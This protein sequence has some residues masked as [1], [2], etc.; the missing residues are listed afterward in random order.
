MSG[1]KKGIRLIGILLVSILLVWLLV[2]TL[3]A[4][5]QPVEA[6][7]K[8]LERGESKPAFRHTVE[9]EHPPLSN[10]AIPDND[11]PPP[12]GEPCGDGEQLPYWAI[13]LHGIVYELNGDGQRIPLDG[14]VISVTLRGRVVTG[15]TFVHPG[16]RTPTYGI[17]ISNLEP[18]FMQPVTLTA[19]FSG[20]VVTYKVPVFPDLRDRNQRFDIPLRQQVTGARRPLA[21][22]TAITPPGRIWG[23]V[24]DFAAGGTIT[25]AVIV[26][27]HDGITEV[28]TIAN[29]AYPW[30]FF[31][32]T[33]DNLTAIGAEDIGDPVTLTTWFN[34]DKQQKVVQ[35]KAEPTQ[36]DLITGWYCD[37]AS[38]L[39]RPGSDDGLPD[40]AGADGLPDTAGADGLPDVGCFWGYI[41]GDEEDLTGVQVQLEIDNALHLDETQLYEGESRPRYGIA[42]RGVEEISGQP[43]TVTTIYTG[44]TVS[45][46]ATINLGSNHNQQIDLL[47]DVVREEAHFQA[48]QAINSLDEYEGIIWAGSKNGLARLDPAT[49]K[50]VTI[51][52]AEGPGNN[53]VEDVTVDGEGKIW[54]IYEGRVFRYDPSTIVWNEFNPEQ[55]GEMVTTITIGRD[56]AIYFGTAS[57]SI[58]SYRSGQ[59]IKWGPPLIDTGLDYIHDLDVD[60]SGN[61]WAAGGS[62][63]IGHY[64]PVIQS[65]RVYSSGNTTN[66]IPRSASIETIVIGNVGDIWAG[67][68]GYG[69]VHYDVNGTWQNFTRTEGGLVSNYIQALGVDDN[70]ALWFGTANGISKY[71]P[72]NEWERQL[73]DSLDGL[74][75]RAIN[76]D[77]ARG[78]IR[79]GTAHDIK[80]HALITGT[81]KAVFSQSTLGSNDIS[82]VIFDSRQTLWIGHPWWVEGVTHYTPTTQSWEVIHGGNITNGA[83]VQAIT[84]D[85]SDKSIWFGT[86]EKGVSHYISPD[87][88][89]VFT[90]TGIPTTGLMSNWIED[91]LI[92]DSNSIWFATS[93]GVSHY[94]P[95]MTPAWETF[96]ITHGLASN[97]INDLDIYNGEIWAATDAGLSL[98]SKQNRDWQTLTETYNLPADSIVSIGID[99][100]RETIW[101]VAPGSWRVGDVVYTPLD[102]NDWTGSWQAI[103]TPDY[104]YQLGNIAIDMNGD[105]WFGSPID[106]DSNIFIY[107]TSQKDWS[108]RKIGSRFDCY[109]SYHIFVAITEERAWLGTECEGM[110]AL[111]IPIK[112]TDLLLRL[113]NPETTLS[114]NTITYTLALTNQGKLATISPTLT[115]A[116]PEETSFVDATLIPDSYAPLTWNLDDLPITGSLELLV[117]ATVQAPPGTELVVSAQATTS[118]RETYKTNNTAIARTSVLDNRPD[119]RVNVIAP[120][121]LEAGQIATFTVQ[122]DNAGGS[123][124]TNT[125]VTVDLDP[126]LTA[127][128]PLP[129]GIGDLPPGSPETFFFPVRV[130]DAASDNTYLSIQTNASTDSEESDLSNNQARA[131]TPTSLEEV[132][133]LFLVADDRM[134]E[135][136]GAAPYL[137]GVYALAEHPAVRGIVVDVF[138]DPDVAAAYATWQQNGYPGNEAANDVATAL[139]QLIN[140]LRLQH[141]ELKYLVIVGGDDVIPFYRVPDRSGTRWRESAY[142]ETAVPRSTVYDALRDDLLLTDDYYTDWQPTAIQSRYW[143]NDASLYL[144][145]LATGRLVE[146][147]AEIR[148]VIDA[149]LANDGMITLGPALVGS[150]IATPAEAALTGDLGNYQCQALEEHGL[151]SGDTCNA[152]MISLRDQAVD[153]GQAIASIWASQ[154]SNHFSAGL[155]RSTEILEY[156]PGYTQA[157]LTTIGCHA[158]LNVPQRPSDDRQID[159]DLAQAFLGQGGTMIGA[160][161][162]GYGSKVGIG[163]SEAVAK[164]LLD[165]LLDSQ[166]TTVGEAL[167]TAKNRYY[168][169]FVGQGFSHLDEKVLVPLTLYGLPMLRVSIPAAETNAIL[170]LDTGLVSSLTTETMNRI[171]ASTV[172]SPVIV[173]NLS[174]NENVEEEGTYY[175]Y[176]GQFIEQSDLPLQPLWQRPLP[177]TAEG[178]TARGVLL[179][180]AAYTDQ[181]PFNPYFGQPWALSQPRATA[182]P[183]SAALTDWDRALPHALGTSAHTVEASLNLVLGAYHGDEQKERLYESLSLEVIYGDGSSNDQVAPT[184]H[185]TSSVRF[186]DRVWIYVRA[187]DESNTVRALGVCDDGQGTWHSVEM[188]QVSEGW[189]GNC[190]PDTARTYVQLMDEAGNVAHSRWQVPELFIPVS[191]AHLPMI[192]NNYTSAPDLIVRDIAITPQSVQMIIENVGTRAITPEDRMWVDLYVDPTPPPAGVNETWNDGRSTHGA[193]WKVSTR[194]APGE[195]LTLTLEDIF[196]DTENSRFPET[197]AVGTPVYAQVDSANTGTDYGV[198]LEIDEIKDEPYNNIVGPVLSAARFP[199]ETTYQQSDIGPPSVS[200]PLRPE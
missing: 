33:E 191:H 145:D 156:T 3:L 77:N 73:D 144:P 40:T 133:T 116:L 103:Q 92:E 146:T 189:S 47:Q 134:T 83:H 8:T 85:L 90:A 102:P 136:F 56:G 199:L 31:A 187:T 179:R 84:E 173:D 78:L 23:Y 162:Y 49:G 67:T 1:V 71:L 106:Q 5:A 11:D 10:T 186:D 139:K 61:I 120:S 192:M 151:V 190:P 81:E 182:T 88:W 183:S 153:S 130:S 65:W 131:S 25:D 66:T 53:L 24:V 35:L 149:F 63:G 79:F 148:A 119:V 166:S 135:R 99:D 110:P 125:L 157:L 147:P 122:A 19:K 200:W 76:I 111:N 124:A 128:S 141:S 18:A 64:S 137:D 55:T 161:A 194:L 50:F 13:C 181:A 43:L 14:A 97:Y 171:N 57:G 94:T 91:I 9:T 52:D 100:L 60:A 30:P 160:T 129:W 180:G 117:T 198:V 48:S 17:D 195:T 126:H 150:T 2:G 132:Q 107:D 45:E 4:A 7:Q 98:Y 62:D 44:A 37:G 118:A 22:T 69:A 177:P 32:L 96:T 101:I 86:R 54:L 167:L 112:Q 16:H 142:A 193:A 178:Y 21:V 41:E 39:A 196:Y 155:L 51:S 172:I 169:Q 28:R 75:V 165:H 20:S 27:E 114:Q 109:D 175:D 184:L 58:H 38:L 105:L 104:S 159:F 89:E 70:N 87:T 46:T 185:L 82:S 6:V 74:D 42:V 59:K 68:S 108:K 80:E 29:D 152:G 113:N 188:S 72:T 12:I 164:A 123:V 95:N 121:Q 163:Y 93:K 174:Y 138:N 127:L 170:P 34:G 176:Q 36:A 115:L 26:A 168:V 154:H 15:T 143:V 140:D 158:G 197:L